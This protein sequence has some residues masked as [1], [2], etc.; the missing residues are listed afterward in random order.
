VKVIIKKEDK[1]LKLGA[2]LIKTL[3]S[4]DVVLLE[5]DLGSGKSVLA[6]GFLNAAGVAVV[7]SPTFTIVNKYD[8]KVGIVYHMDAYRLDGIEEAR[9]SGL[10]EIIDDKNSIKFIEWPG[11]LTEILP[12]KYTK[13][14]I[15]KIDDMTREVTIEVNK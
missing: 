9:A 1:M 14:V 12:K 3:K 13:I 5:G 7:P 6:R 11:R 8:T 15:K 10:D 4:G 2:G